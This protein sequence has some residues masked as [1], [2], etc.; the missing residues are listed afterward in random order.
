MNYGL[1][2]TP[3]MHRRL[4]SAI[5]SQLALP[6]ESAPNFQWEKFKW[7][8]TVDKKNKKKSERDNRG[9]GTGDLARAA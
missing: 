2:K 1:T 6:E 8:N 4:S 3:S 7:N 5:L 9:G